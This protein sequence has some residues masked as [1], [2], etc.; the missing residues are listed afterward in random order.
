M[1]GGNASG[2]IGTPGR[3]LTFALD[4]KATLPATPAPPSAPSTMKLDADPKKIEAGSLQ[5]ARWCMYCHG[6]GASS[7]G[8]IRDLRYSAESVFGSYPKIVLD[9]AYASTGMPSYK[10]WLSTDDV[11]A[12]RA[13]VI[14]Q[15]NR[16]ASK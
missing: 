14:S 10:Q 2:A 11:A 3:L 12:I 16:L 5:Y 4:G 15:R 6:F 7:G 13:Y 8:A 1:I 9:G